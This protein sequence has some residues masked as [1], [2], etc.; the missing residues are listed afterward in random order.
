MPIPDRSSWQTDSETVKETTKRHHN[1]NR[2]TWFRTKGDMATAVCS[3]SFESHSSHSGG[4]WEGGNWHC[5]L[6]PSWK[7]L[8]CSSW[9]KFQPHKWWTCPQSTCMPCACM[10]EVPTRSC[11]QSS[12]VKWW[13]CGH[14]DIL[15]VWH[16]SEVKPGHWAGVSAFHICGVTPLLQN[17]TQWSLLTHVLVED[18]RYFVEVLAKQTAQRLPS[19]YCWLVD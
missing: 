11:L 8:H 18:L 16:S 1:V 5:S 17:A 9:V 13:L 2:R 14:K 6:T 7:G 4:V 10:D 19:T 3:E 15:F 12:I